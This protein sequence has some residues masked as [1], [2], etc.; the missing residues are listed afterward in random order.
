MFFRRTDNVRVPIKLHAN[1]WADNFRR[2]LLTIGELYISLLLGHSPPPRYVVPGLPGIALVDSQPSGF[3]VSQSLAE[4]TG[5]QML[6]WL[7]RS[8]CSCLIQVRPGGALSR[9]D[10]SACR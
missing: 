3:S 7:P 8:V 1:Y 5:S 2:S 4:R 9:M 10:K 6:S